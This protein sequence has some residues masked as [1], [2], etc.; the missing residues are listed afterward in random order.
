M[1]SE[2]DQHLWKIRLLKSSIDRSIILEHSLDLIAVVAD[3]RDRCPVHSLPA[4]SGQFVCP[5]CG[6]LQ[7]CANILQHSCAA[8]EGQSG[9]GMW[10]PTSR[11]L[12]S[13]LTGKVCVRAHLMADRFVLLCCVG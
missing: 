5:P 7:A 1:S 8:S 2:C 10:D 3:G 12:H 13:L 4:V 6:M 11:K 9:A